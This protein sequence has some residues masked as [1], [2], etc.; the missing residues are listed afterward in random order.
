MSGEQRLL[1]VRCVDFASVLHLPEDSSSATPLFRF[2]TSSPVV[3]I[4]LSDDGQWCAL[5]TTQTSKLFAL[6]RTDLQV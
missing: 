2:N 3:A 5:S 6:V 4:G 1:M